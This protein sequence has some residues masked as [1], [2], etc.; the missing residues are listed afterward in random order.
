MADPQTRSRNRTEVEEYKMQPLKVREVDEAG[1]SRK[2]STTDLNGQDAASNQNLT[3]R[4]DHAI[5]KRNN[6]V[7]GGDK[8]SSTGDEEDAFSRMSDESQQWIIRKKTEL[9]VETDRVSAL[10]ERK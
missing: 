2:S 7:V 9:T 5:F 1:S 4:P 6:V 3:L 8:A 10:S